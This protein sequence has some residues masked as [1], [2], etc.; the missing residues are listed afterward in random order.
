MQNLWNNI[1]CLLMLF[2]FVY[3]K[4]IKIDNIINDVGKIFKR[5]VK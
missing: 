2:D 3:S 1:I 5:N 4:V